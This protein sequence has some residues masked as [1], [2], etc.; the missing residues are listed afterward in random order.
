MYETF[1]SLISHS[2][3]QIANQLYEAEIEQISISLLSDNPKQY[4]QIIQPTDPQ[5]YGFSTVCNFIIA[6]VER[7]LMVTCTAI[8]RPDVDISRVRKLS[9]ALGAQSFKTYSYHP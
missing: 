3:S 9:E 7:G 1:L 4:S 5:N 2:S 6:C 8:E